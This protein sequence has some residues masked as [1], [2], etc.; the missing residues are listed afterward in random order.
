MKRTVRSGT[1]LKGTAVEAHKKDSALREE[2][3]CKVTTPS[4]PA[5]EPSDISDQSSKQAC[6]CS[7]VAF[8]LS[9]YRVSVQ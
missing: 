1:V 2:E 7:L 6:G 3:A 4:R 5:P 8:A 9:W